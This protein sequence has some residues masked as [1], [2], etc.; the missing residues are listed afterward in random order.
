MSSYDGKL[1]WYPP[2]VI[3]PGVGTAKTFVPDT[4]VEEPFTLL[5][6]DAQVA[7]RGKTTS[8]CWIGSAE[9]RV[10]GGP[11]SLK[12]D[13]RYSATQGNGAKTTIF[14]VIGA[15][16]KPIS[17]D[18]EKDG[19]FT[20]TYNAS[21]GNEPTQ[22]ITIILLAER[23]ATDVDLVVSVNSLDITKA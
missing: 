23:S 16:F 1:R 17:F 6:E 22:T 21:I 13:A 20:E 9:F 3:T 10:T 12:V 7:L 8:G 19:D 18:D 4:N 15:V 11:A 5:L 2:T 14:I